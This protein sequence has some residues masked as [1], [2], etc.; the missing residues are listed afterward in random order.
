MDKGRRGME[1]LCPSCCPGV[2]IPGPGRADHKR[3]VWVGG[4]CPWRGDGCSWGSQSMKTAHPIEARL[5]RG[6]T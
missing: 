5:L 6:Q 2:E 3:N 1:H 4:F